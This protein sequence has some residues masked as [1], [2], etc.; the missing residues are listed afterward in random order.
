MTKLDTAVLFSIIVMEEW[1]K[2]F[3]IIIS[4]YCQKGD[5]AREVGDLLAYSQD[6]QN[7]RPIRLVFI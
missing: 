7:I 1:K 5:K 4:M 2:A 6:I 3:D